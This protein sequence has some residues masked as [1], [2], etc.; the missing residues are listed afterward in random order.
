MSKDR[1]PQ[2]LR[3]FI[4]FHKLEKM[5]IPYVLSLISLLR[6]LFSLYH[7]RLIR[8]K[9]YCRSKRAVKRI[10]ATDKKWTEMKPQIPLTWKR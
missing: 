2:V 7:G 9:F 8:F 1:Y 10:S 3:P 4:K 6:L 5:S